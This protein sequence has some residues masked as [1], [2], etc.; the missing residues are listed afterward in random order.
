MLTSI[1][2]VFL[3]K[4]F[5]VF[6]MNTFHPKCKFEKP[7]GSRKYPFSDNIQKMFQFRFQNLGYILA[8]ICCE[9]D[10]KHF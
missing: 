6:F 4:Y 9:S 5:G 7:V 2:R 8:D 10:F 3:A 1:R